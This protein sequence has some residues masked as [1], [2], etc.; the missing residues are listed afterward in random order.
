MLKKI[1]FDIINICTP[2]YLHFKNIILSIKFNKNILVEKPF[3]TSL[4][5]L[6]IIKNK[7]TYWY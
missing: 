5:D 1:D 2:P 4:K 6:L 7:N 3:V